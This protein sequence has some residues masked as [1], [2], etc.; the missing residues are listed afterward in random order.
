MYCVEQV[1]LVSSISSITWNRCIRSGKTEPMAVNKLALIRY[2]AINDCLRNRYR[3]WT[4]E[5]L[6]EK[7]G[8]VLYESEGIASGVSRRTIQADIQ[9]MRSDKASRRMPSCANSTA[10]W[11]SAGLIGTVWRGPAGGDDARGRHHLGHAR[12]RRGKAGHTLGPHD[13]RPCDQSARVGVARRL[14]TQRSGPQRALYQPCVL[15]IASPIGPGLRIVSPKLMI[16][17]IR[18]LAL[19]CR[20]VASS[21]W[22]KLLPG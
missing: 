10:R 6:I 18:E 7:V 4:L 22:A 11:H 14:P 8:D 19:P 20:N 9:F 3:R 1:Q 2:K 12:R 13:D 17:V 5:D 15:R 21:R 16:G